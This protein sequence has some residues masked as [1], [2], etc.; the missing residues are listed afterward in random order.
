MGSIPRQQPVFVHNNIIKNYAS[1]GDFY[2]GCKLFD[3]MSLR[4][5]VSYNTMISACCQNGFLEGAWK[6]F[7][8]MRKCDF[9]P[10][11]FTFGGLL[12]CDSLAIFEGMQLQAQIEKNGLFCADPFP[13]T[14]LLSMYG[15][16]GCLDESIGVFE[17]MPEKN[18][19]SWNCMISLFGQMGLVE[20]CLFMLRD[21]MRSEI[22]VSEY[23][24]LGIL[25]CCDRENELQLGEQMHGAVIKFGFDCVA[26]VSNSLL[27]MYAKCDSTCSAEKYFKQVP[28]KDIVSWNTLIGAMV[29]SAT[30]ARAFALFLEMCVHGFLP[31]ETTFVNVLN[32]CTTTQTSRYGELIHAK[33][34]K[35]RFESDV[36][37]GSG[38]VDFYA[39]CDKVEEAHLC[40]DEITEKT[41]VSWNSLMLGYSKRDFS[42]S[43]RL[44]K[45]MIYLGSQPNEFSFSIVIK[46]SLPLELFQ[47]HA[48]TIKMGYQENAYVSSSLI[49]SYAR[50]G[51]VSDALIF[52]ASDNMPLSVASSNVIAGIYNRTGQYERT[53]E[54]FALVEEPDIVSWNILIAACSR[55]GDYKEVF[56]LLD[57]MRRALVSPDNYTYVSLFSVCTKLCNLALGSSLHGLIMKTRFKSCDT[58]VCNIMIDMYGKCGS[59]ES[60]V[61]IFNEITKRNVISWTALISALG[62]HGHAIEAL[63]K[64]REM[65]AEG[66]WPDK[67]AFLAVLSSCRHAGDVEQGM[68]LFGQMKSKYR[69]EP[70][71]DHYLLVVDLLARY[72]YLKEAERLIL[73]MPFPPNALIWRSFLEGCKRQ[74]TM[75]DLAL[76][77]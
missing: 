9:K 63:N 64:F 29:K 44:L 62:L 45:D 66:F 19:V 31:N 38:L 30:P 22:G 75:E 17:S 10:T 18:L 25:S 50:N 41:S 40:F 47:L 39:K 8:N 61:K 37:T 5:V 53:Q 58:F 27:N 55:N 21:L 7:S 67:V 35:K 1:F 71:M 34:I 42:V 26:S 43:V 11:Q 60:S 24:F 57:H 48:L 6:L 54:L 36:Y 12:S 23:S 2:S 72:G 51:F 52:V 65:E 14:A 59:P 73:G 74:R 15:R 76:A 16:H 70:E 13:G 20:N 32:S 77:T 46:S 68:E 33:M 3:E 56:E 4:N 49:S 28:V 69:V